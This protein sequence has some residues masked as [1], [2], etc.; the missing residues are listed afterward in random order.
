MTLAEGQALVGQL[1]ALLPPAGEEVIH[2]QVHH[3][4]DGRGDGT[5]FASIADHPPQRLT[6]VRDAVDIG[7]RPGNPVD[8][9]HVNLVAQAGDRGV[10]LRERRRR[11]AHRV[12]DGLD[13]Q[14][15]G[16]G[17]ARREAGEGHMEGLP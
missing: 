10:E 9:D 8:A 3:R 7:C 15:Q 6:A 12:G 14:V 13:F 17:D 1:S 16:R 11:G 4:E 2:A 5:S